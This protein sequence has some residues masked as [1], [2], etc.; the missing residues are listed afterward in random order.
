MSHT[1]I[2]DILQRLQSLQTELEAEIDSLLEEK[3]QLFHYTLEKGK[4]RFEQG[5]KS[6]QRHQ[7]IGLWHYLRSAKISHLLTAPVIYSLFIPLLLLDIMVSIYQQICFRVYKI[8]LVQRKEYVIIDRQHLAYLNAIEKL[9]CIYC[10]YSNGLIEYIR[11]ISA[12]TEQY[13][14]PIKH[15]RRSPDPHRLMNNFEDYGNA[16][17]VHERLLELR[18]EITHIRHDSPGHH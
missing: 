15:A 7:K 2:D 4:V 9:N 12:R 11:E 1:S 10:G 6:L 17:N 5:M 18:R 14:C 3:R 16:E 13:W 8:P